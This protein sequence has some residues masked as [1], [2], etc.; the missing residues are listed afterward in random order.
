MDKIETA[1]LKYKPDRIRCLFI[2]EAPPKQGSE[3]FFYFENV[4]TQD[5]LFLE[6]MK[7]LYPN[8]TR[9]V[10]AKVIRDRKEDLLTHFKEDGFYLIDSLDIPFDKK[11]S[12][13]QKIK[14]LKENQAGLLEKVK[15]LIRED[16]RVILISATVYHAN[17]NFL[18]SKGIPILNTELVDF[19]GS[20]GQ[21]KFNMKM[22]RL[23]QPI[24][25]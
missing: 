1:R 11:Y 13:S 10:K 25:H 24:F 7:Y 18:F 22:P 2:A 4:R 15:S 17:Y 19:P 20:G 14:L 23:L 6:L 12:N 8:S 5:T 16:T 21:K 9:G 3:R